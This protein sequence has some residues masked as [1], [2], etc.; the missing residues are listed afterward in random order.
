MKVLKSG[1]NE[2]LLG[3]TIHQGLNRQ[4]R[5]MLAGVGLRVQ[6][7]KRTRIGPLKLEGLGVGKYRPL[8]KAEV[9]SLKRAAE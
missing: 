4:I 2:S 9:A 6:S 5:R 3:I 8:T 1:H 7:L